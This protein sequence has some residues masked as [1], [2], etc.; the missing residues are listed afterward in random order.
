MKRSDFTEILQN[1]S[2]KHLLFVLDDLIFADI[3]DQDREGCSLGKIIKTSSGYWSFI[4]L[5][6]WVYLEDVSSPSYNFYCYECDEKGN[7][8]R[9]LGQDVE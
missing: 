8:I 3:S 4:R 2:R 1:N 7:Y 9:W 6:E 5:P